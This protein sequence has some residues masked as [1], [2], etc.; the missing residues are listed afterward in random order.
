ML[1]MDH[2]I[3]QEK[4]LYKFHNML[5]VVGIR[6]EVHGDARVRWS[7]GSGDDERTY[8]GHENFIELKTYLTGSGW[9]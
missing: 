9:M 5:S 8:H 1:P 7:E 3:S 2:R 4:A 6:L